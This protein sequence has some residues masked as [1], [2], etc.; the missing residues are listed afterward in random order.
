MLSN[1][2]CHIKLVWIVLWAS[3]LVRALPDIPPEQYSH[4]LSVQ[5]PGESGHHGRGRVCGTFPDGV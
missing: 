2:I 4:P 3:L 1:P 5:C